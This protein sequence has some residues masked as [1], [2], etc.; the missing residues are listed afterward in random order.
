M[1]GKNRTG[2]FPFAGSHSPDEVAAE[3]DLQLLPK[4]NGAVSCWRRIERLT[5][6]ILRKSSC[7]LHCDY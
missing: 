6:R 7:R 4:I 5:L 3:T 2:R 1:S